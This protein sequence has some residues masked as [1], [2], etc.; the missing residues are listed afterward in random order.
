MLDLVYSEYFVINDDGV[1]SIAV[2]VVVV[3]IVDDD[4]D[5]DGDD[6]DNAAAAAAA[7]ATDDDDDED[8][9]VSIIIIWLA[10]RAGKMS[11]ILRCDW[12][13]EWST[14]SYLSCSGLPVAR[15][16]GI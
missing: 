1:E 7:A 6:N 8:D 11:Q 16:L 5:D 13:P 14:W 12:L 2:D 10:P 15:S 9:G 4:D 3:V